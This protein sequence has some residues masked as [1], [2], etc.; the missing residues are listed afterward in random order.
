MMATA[1]SSSRANTP[2]V[3]PASLLAERENCQKVSMPAVGYR[4]VT[5]VS[6]QILSVPQ[7][8][9]SPAGAGREEG[10]DRIQQHQ[11]KTKRHPVTAKQMHVQYQ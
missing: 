2:T 4:V 6:D 7:V 8:V 9:T 3:Y 5:S 10:L 11:R 1:W